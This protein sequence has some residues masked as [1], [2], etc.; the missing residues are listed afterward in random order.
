MLMASHLVHMNDFYAKLSGMELRD[1]SA[2]K[3]LPE[4]AQRLTVALQGP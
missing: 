2:W 4:Q 1:E 3:L